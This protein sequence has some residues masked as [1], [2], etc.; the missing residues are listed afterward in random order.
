MSRGLRGLLI[1]GILLGSANV[2]FAQPSL[3]RLFTTQ[4]Q[5]LEIDRLKQQSGKSDNT[6]DFTG[7]VSQKAI[8]TQKEGNT[9]SVHGLVRKSDGKTWVWIQQ[10]GKLK[11]SN[12]HDYQG[13]LSGSQESSVLIKVNSSKK[14][15]KIKP[16]QTYI[17]SRDKVL[18]NWQLGAAVTE[19][20]TEATPDTKQPVKTNTQKTIN[21]PPKVLK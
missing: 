11:R 18:D 16:G 12:G 21:T 3:E 15:I 17:R 7:I 20:S 4:Q 9:V 13:L 5:R 19:T 1:P 6:G 8:H 10:N 14:D 2:C